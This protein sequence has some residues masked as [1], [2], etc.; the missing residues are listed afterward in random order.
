MN[1]K[2]INT[3]IE[4]NA[5]KSTDFYKFLLLQILSNP[6]MKTKNVNNGKK[7]EQRDKKKL[8]LKE[9]QKKEVQ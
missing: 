7:N 4:H 8:N 3:Y 5:C 2:N 1:K 6:M 9:Q